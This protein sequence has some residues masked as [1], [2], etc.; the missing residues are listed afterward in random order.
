MG[1]SVTGHQDVNVLQAPF[2]FVVPLL[3]AL[4]ADVIQLY[5]KFRAPCLTLNI[6]YLF[7]DL[8]ASPCGGKS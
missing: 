6:L 1:L 3:F 2:S 4:A 5:K 7:T 8:K